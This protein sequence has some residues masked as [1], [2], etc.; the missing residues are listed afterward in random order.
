M[1]FT[2]NFEKPAQVRISMNTTVILTQKIMD[3]S[4]KQDT[5]KARTDSPTTPF[6]FTLTSRELFKRLGYEAATKRRS[7]NE[8]KKELHTPTA[9]QMI[10]A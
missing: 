10:R 3:Q 2:K 5:F 4:F 9:E 8:S 1:T 6:F 7:G